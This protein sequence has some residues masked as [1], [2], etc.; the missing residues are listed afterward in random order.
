MHLHPNC[1]TLC[2]Q[3]SIEICLGASSGCLKH[4]SVLDICIAGLA[5]YG[6]FGFLD[7]LSAN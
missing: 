4:L 7:I 2:D 6:S 3:V 5:V 1:W